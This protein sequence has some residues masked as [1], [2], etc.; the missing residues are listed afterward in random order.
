MFKQ[1]ELTTDGFGT[2]VT[3]FLS[4]YAFRKLQIHEYFGSQYIYYAHKQ[5]RINLEE[6]DTTNPFHLLRDDK[7]ENWGI[8]KK[9]TISKSL[10]EEFRCTNLKYKIKLKDK[11][12][13]I[14]ITK[15]LISENLCRT[16]EFD[17]K[18]KDLINSKRISVKGTKVSS[19]FDD[20]NRKEIDAKIGET[21]FICKGHNQPHIA[22]PCYV[23]DVNETCETLN[24]IYFTNVIDYFTE[25]NKLE[26]NGWCF[27][28]VYKYELGRT[29]EEAVYNFR[30]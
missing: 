7:F 23:F 29:P 10:W 8:L 5:W 18:V 25:S 26:I 30:Q 2:L 9:D 16:I 3:N 14:D 28:T 12:R 1:I 17:N 6:I 15:R 20:S 27:D 24:V 4:D 13:F 22:N 11:N 21:Y 19:Y